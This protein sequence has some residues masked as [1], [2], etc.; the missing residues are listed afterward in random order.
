MQRAQKLERNSLK[1]SA[2]EPHKDKNDATSTQQL[3]QEDTI[4]Y[5]EKL[6]RRRQLEERRR[7]RDEEI[8][9]SRAVTYDVTFDIKVDERIFKLGYNAGQDPR[10]VAQDFVWKNNLWRGHLDPIAE[11]L[12]KGT[13]H[14]TQSHMHSTT[15]PHPG[16]HAQPEA[17]ADA[18][19][20][21][22]PARGNAVAPCAQ[23]SEGGEGVSD[24]RPT[25]VSPTEGG[26][27]VSDVRPRRVGVLRIES[28]DE[29]DIVP[30]SPLCTYVREDSELGKQLQ[31]MDD[32]DWG[33]V[34]RGVSG[35]DSSPKP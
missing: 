25:H 19:A 26:V 12:C 34:M 1:K 9:H 14:L 10:R 11:F 33:Q 6:E 27:G 29:L 32:E 2:Q 18:A 30:P 35:M 23:G 15:L 17:A 3:H 16:A 22:L 7:L 24:V 28:S 31:A 4:G 5:E 13:A 21:K 20:P 8:R